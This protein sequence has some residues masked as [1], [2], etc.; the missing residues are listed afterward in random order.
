[1]FQTDVESLIQLHAKEGEETD[2]LRH[3]HWNCFYRGTTTHTEK[4]AMIFLYEKRQC[5]SLTC[6]LF[7]DPVDG[8]PPGSSVHGSLQASSLERVARPFSRGSS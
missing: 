7:C 5:Y 8:R 1:M 3:F 4:S 6:I 2:I